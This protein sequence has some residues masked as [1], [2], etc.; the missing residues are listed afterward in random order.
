MLK[1]KHFSSDLI[2]KAVDGD[3]ASCFKL[4]SFLSQCNVEM[5]RFIFIKF[6]HDDAI[7]ICYK[8]FAIHIS[9][10]EEDLVCRL[11]S[12]CYRFRKVSND[13]CLQ[14]L[15]KHYL[16]YQDICYGWSILF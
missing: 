9:F 6:G 8:Y 15:K 7:F 3:I 2:R 13:S 1:V 11:K 5:E 4:S 14:S 16:D 10:L 12:H